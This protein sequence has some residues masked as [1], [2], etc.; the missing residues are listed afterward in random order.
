MP[1]YG[2]TERMTLR[3]FISD[4][5]LPQEGK[6]LWFSI[7]EKIDEFQIKVYADFIGG[8]EKNLQELTANLKTKTEALKTLDEKAMEK[9]IEQEV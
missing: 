4:S 9:I 6:D 1:K 5:S 3:V 8:E 7:L 2:Y